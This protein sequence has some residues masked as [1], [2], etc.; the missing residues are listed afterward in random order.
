MPIGAVRQTVAVLG[1]ILIVLLIVVV[2]PVSV[3]ISGG[4][5]AGVLGFFLKK[6]VDDEFAGTEEL[7]LS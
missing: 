4:I 2:I 6:D 7:E 1:P 3:F 5:F